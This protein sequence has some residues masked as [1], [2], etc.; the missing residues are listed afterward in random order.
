MLCLPHSYCIDY[1]MFSHRA[2]AKGVLVRAGNMVWLAYV[3]SI[4]RRIAPVTMCNYIA[5]CTRY[6]HQD[7]PS[8]ISTTCSA[9]SRRTGY[10]IAEESPRATIQERLV[11]GLHK[12]F[13]VNKA[14]RKGPPFWQPLGCKR[15]ACGRVAGASRRGHRAYRRNTHRSAWIKSKDC[16]RSTRISA[17][18]LSQSVG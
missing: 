10:P 18:G 4:T 9:A 5:F 13:A 14:K 16:A 11:I 12:V 17:A 6:A 7:D 15:A 8:P 1:A 3:A 2:V